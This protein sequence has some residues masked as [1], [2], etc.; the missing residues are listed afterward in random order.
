MSDG[1][2]KAGTNDSVNPIKNKLEFQENFTR[3]R[4]DHGLCPW[5]SVHLPS[6]HL[7]T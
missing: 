2:R 4:E 7:Y 1:F 5:R 3:L 6:R